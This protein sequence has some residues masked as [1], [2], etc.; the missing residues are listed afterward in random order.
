MREFQS[1]GHFLR[2][3]ELQKCTRRKVPLHSVPRSR[4]RTSGHKGMRFAPEI[5]SQALVR[6]ACPQS[7]SSGKRTTMCRGLCA[8]LRCLT[9]VPPAYQ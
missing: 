1:A 3:R 8:I 7:R 4:R 6:I 2:V 9:R 5:A